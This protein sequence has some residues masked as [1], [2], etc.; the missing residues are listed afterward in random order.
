[1][2]REPESCKV[3]YCG[4]LNPRTPDEVSFEILGLKS[5]IKTAEQ[6]ISVLEQSRYLAEAMVLSESEEEV[7][8]LDGDI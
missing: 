8:E 3:D 6:R 2:M 4:Y 1:M 5:L 7:K